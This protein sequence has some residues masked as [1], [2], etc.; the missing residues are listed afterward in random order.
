MASGA[1]EGVATR[2]DLLGG[3]GVGL[4][5]SSS[6]G[7]DCADVRNGDGDGVPHSGGEVNGGDGGDGRHGGGEGE[8]QGHAGAL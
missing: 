6:G 7:D 8:Q 5:G 4:R 1:A 2:G 3:K